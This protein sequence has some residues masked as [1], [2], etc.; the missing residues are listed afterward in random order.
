MKKHLTIFLSFLLLVVYA[1]AQEEVSKP[2]VIK[3]SYF[4]ISPPLRD[5]VKIL[6]TPADLTWKNQVVKNFYDPRRNQPTD[7]ENTKV[8]DPYLQTWNGSLNADTVVQSFD[9]LPNPQGY[10]P[11]DTDG[12]VGPDHFFQIV[13]CSFAVYTKTGT[14]LIGPLLNSSIFSGLPNNHND[15][16]GVVLY[17]ENADR[18][19]FSQFSLPNFPNGPFFEMVAISQ[20][21]DPT[22]SW[23][24]YQFQFSD[25]PDYPKLGVW[26]DGYYLTC[27]RFSAGST[28]FMGTGAAALNRTKMIAGDPSAEMV[29]FTLPSNNDAYAVLP[30]D[31]DGTFPAAGTP[32][33]FTYFNNSPDRMDIRAFH[34]DWDNTA[35]ST[36]NLEKQ[37]PVNAFTPFPWSAGIPQKGTSVKVAAMGDRLMYRS[38]LRTF[39]DHLSIVACHSVNVGSGVSG[40]RWYELRKEGSNEWMVYQQGTYNPDAD[41]RWMGSIAMDSSGNIALG[42]SIASS[43]RYPSVYYTGRTSCDP[44]GEMTIAEG[45]IVDGTGSQTNTWSGNPSRWGDY[46][47][48]SVDPVQPSTFWYTQEY[49]KTVSDNSWKTRIGSISFANIF[50]VTTTAD[51]DSLCLSDQGST[52][53]NAETCGGSGPF[54]YSW[55]SEPPGF[56]STEK[57]PTAS[58]VVTTN[59]IC[60]VT[61]GNQTK[62]DTVLVTVLGSP[63]VFAGN[64]TSY[65]W[66]VPAF[67]LNGVVD[68]YNSVKWT[69]LGDGNFNI[70]TLLNTLYFTGQGDRDLGH[71]TLVLTAF[72]TELCPDTVSDEIYIILDPCT[73]LPEVSA[74]N[75]GISIQPNPAKNMV[76]LTIGGMKN[77]EILITISDMQGRAVLTERVEAAGKTLTRSIDVSQYRKGAYLVKVQT[78]KEIKTERMIVQ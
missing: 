10:C 76:L 32:N 21:A 18:W 46:S 4:D 50:S 17:D 42:Y 49:Y 74:E 65:C 2:I 11:P 53:L 75:L 67:P 45:I 31:C 39:S 73:G 28:N 43:T 47:A 78:D 71:V 56:T 16:D 60:A 26:P 70:D 1:F 51:P 41:N 37:L 57:N 12:D 14:K 24:R 9:G 25:M 7:S 38:Q 3:A 54:T 15:G 35:N 36:Y 44:L 68:Y 33:Y 22:G 5:M 34:V 69:T 77:N 23:Y 48:M 40:I 66:Y 29:Y 27:N 61:D 13:N 55:T 62:T 63:S 72:V 30:A 8:S 52:Q 64:D 19:L 59:Y 6:P 58:P 20:T